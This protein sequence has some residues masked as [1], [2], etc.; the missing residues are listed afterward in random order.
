[1]DKEN[2]NNQENMKGVISMFNK[3][4]WKKIVSYIEPGD[5][6][7]RIFHQPVKT[8]EASAARSMLRASTPTDRQVGK[9]KSFSTSLNSA[10]HAGTSNS[11]FL[12]AAGRRL[13]SLGDVRA[14][15]SS[16]RT[17]ARERTFE[18]VR[19]LKATAGAKFNP[20][21]IAVP[22]TA[23]LRAHLETPAG[24]LSKFDHAGLTDPEYERTQWGA[25]F[26]AL[27][28]G[29]D[30]ILPAAL[31]TVPGGLQRTGDGGFTEQLQ[32]FGY[33]LPTYET[34]IKHAVGQSGE[35]KV[36]VAGASAKELTSLSSLIN[37]MDDGPRARFQAVVRSCFLA[38]ASPPVG[39]LG[40]PFPVGMDKES[41]QL[42]ILDKLGTRLAETLFGDTTGNKNLQRALTVLIREYTTVFGVKADREVT[43]APT[44][45]T[46]TATIIGDLS[47]A[48]RLDTFKALAAVYNLLPDS[49]GPESFNSMVD[50]LD[51]TQLTALHTNLTKATADG[52]LGLA[53]NI[54]PALAAGGTDVATLKANIKGAAYNGP[55]RESAVIFALEA[56]QDK[57]LATLSS[58]IETMG[59][60]DALPQ[61][62]GNFAGRPWAN[63]VVVGEFLA[64]LSVA[65][66]G[67][68]DDMG[69]ITQTALNN[70]EF[71]GPAL[72]DGIIFGEGDSVRIEDVKGV[73]AGI[74]G[75]SSGHG[76]TAMD[77]FVV[78]SFRE[79]LLPGRATGTHA[80]SVVDFSTR[81]FGRL[82]QGNVDI[83]TVRERKTA[84]SAPLT[85]AAVLTALDDIGLEA[86]VRGRAKMLPDAAGKPVQVVY[87]L[88][89]GVADKPMCEL[90]AEDIETRYEWDGTGYA[91]KSLGT[92]IGRAALA[93]EEVMKLGGTSFFLGGNV[94]EL[95]ATGDAV[96]HKVE[97]SNL[98]QIPYD[99]A[100]TG[101]ERKVMH[102]GTDR[103]DGWYVQMTPAEQLADFDGQ[104]QY[105]GGTTT[106]SASDLE[107]LGRAVGMTGTFTAP[108]IKAYL[109]ANPG[110]IQTAMKTIAGIKAEQAFDASVG[111][112]SDAEAKA[113]FEALVSGF[114]KEM[115]VDLGNRLGF[116]ATPFSTTNR[117][118]I[119]NYI[120]HN[121][122]LTLPGGVLCGKRIT[123]AKIATRMIAEMKQGTEVP[124][125]KAIGVPIHG[126]LVQVDGKLL[127]VAG[128]GVFVAN[129]RSAFPVYTVF[130][131]CKVGGPAGSLIDLAIG[132]E[133]TVVF[134]D[135]GAG[136]QKAF[137]RNTVDGTM[138]SVHEV[139]VLDTGSSR[140]L[141]IAGQ[142]DIGGGRWFAAGPP[143]EETQDVKHFD[144]TLDATHDR[145]QTVTI[146][147]N[148]YS[149]QANGSYAAVRDTLRE[150][151][152]SVGGQ[153][154]SLRHSGEADLQ[155]WSI[156]TGA[157]ASTGSGG[158]TPTGGVLTKHTAVILF[159]EGA[160]I[161]VDSDGKV[162]V[163]TFL[164][165]GNEVVVQK[166]GHGGTAD[167]NIAKK[168]NMSLGG[169]FGV[170]PTQWNLGYFVL[171]GNVQFLK[172]D[173]TKP[174]S[175]MKG[176]DV[177]PLGTS[178][179]Y[180]I[181]VGVEPGGTTPIYNYVVKNTAGDYVTANC[182]ALDGISRLSYTDGAVSKDMFIRGDAVLD[183]A[184]I[185]QDTIFNGGA[186][187]QVSYLFTSEEA[188]TGSPR[189]YRLDAGGTQLAKAD[190]G[191]ATTVTAE[192][193][194]PDAD[195][196]KL[197]ASLYRV[198]QSI[199]DTTKQSIVPMYE[200]DGVG[201]GVTSYEALTQYDP[202][203]FGDTRTARIT[204]AALG[205]EKLENG[206]YAYYSA[207]RQMYAYPVDASGLFYRWS[208]AAIKEVGDF[209]SDQVSTPMTVKLEKQIE[210]GFM[211]L[212][213]TLVDS[214]ILTFSPS[215]QRRFTGDAS[216]KKATL[217]K[218]MVADGAQWKQ[219][220]T[221]LRNKVL[222]H[223]CHE[224]KMGLRAWLNKLDMVQLT[225]F[226]ENQKSGDLSGL[227]DIDFSA[228]DIAT[229][230]TEVFA[231]ILGQLHIKEA[232]GIFSQVDDTSLVDFD[233]LS[234]V[235]TSARETHKAS[236]DLALASMADYSP[237]ILGESAHKILDVLTKPTTED[238]VVCGLNI[239]GLGLT[240][241]AGTTITNLGDSLFTPAT[242]AVFDQVLAVVTTIASLA[243]LKTQLELLKQTPGAIAAIVAEPTAGDSNLLGVDLAGC[244]DTDEA[245]I[246]FILNAKGNAARVD[247]ADFSVANLALAGAKQIV[248][249]KLVIAAEDKVVEFRAL[250]GRF[251]DVQLLEFLSADNNPTDNG[252]ALG[253][254]DFSGKNKA[255]IITLVIDTGKANSNPASSLD[256]GIRCATSRL[257][258]TAV[259]GDTETAL[260]TLLGK[261]PD[262]ELHTFA[263]TLV[264]A[265]YDATGVDITKSGVDYVVAQLKAGESNIT[266]TEYDA[267]FVAVTALATTALKAAMDATAI[268]LAAVLEQFKTGVDAGGAVTY[269]ERGL[270]ACFPSLSSGAPIPARGKDDLVTKYLS[271]ADPMGALAAANTLATT[272]LDGRRTALEVELTTTLTGATTDPSTNALQPGWQQFC[273][274][275]GG[276]T[277]IAGYVTTASGAATTSL[278]T[279]AKA[280]IFADAQIAS[281]LVSLQANIRTNIANLQDGGALSRIARTTMGISISGGFT[282][283]TT[284]RSAILA[285]LSNTAL[286]V[287][288]QVS[289]EILTALGLFTANRATSV[290]GLLPNL[291]V[292]DLRA[293]LPLIISNTDIVDGGV[294]TGYVAGGLSTYTAVRL[295]DYITTGTKQEDAAYTALEGI[296]N[297]RRQD[298]VQAA[299]AQIAVIVARPGGDPEKLQLLE[300]FRVA[301]SIDDFPADK[302]TV[303]D[304]SAWLGTQIAVNTKNTGEIREAADLM[305]QVTDF[306][307]G[308]DDIASANAG[309]GTNITE[310][311]QQAILVA[312]LHPTVF[313]A[314]T[315]TVADRVAH[316]KTAVIRKPLA[317]IRIS[318]GKAT[319]LLARERASVEL[320]VVLGA[321]A[322]TSLADPVQMQICRFA[323]KQLTGNNAMEFGTGAAAADKAVVATDDAAGRAAFLF[324]PARFAE[325]NAG[326]DATDIQAVKVRL[327]EVK[328]K[329]EKFRDLAEWMAQIEVVAN[330]S[331]A[332]QKAALNSL[333][334][335]AD[336]KTTLAECRAQV[337]EEAA[338]QTSNIDEMIAKASAVQNL[339]G[340][341]V[342]ITRIAGLS[343]A[344]QLAALKSMIPTA[345]AR[346]AVNDV[347]SGMARI[348]EQEVRALAPDKVIATADNNVL[349]RAEPTK[350]YAT[351]L[352]GVAQDL[353]E[354][355]AKAV[356]TGVMAHAPTTFAP[357]TVETRML[358][359]LS[360]AAFGNVAPNDIDGNKLQP[361]VAAKAASEVTWTAG[362]ITNVNT[363]LDGIAGLDL[364]A[365]GLDA[366]TGEP[367][368]LA[369]LTACAQFIEGDAGVVY[370]WDVVAT[371]NQRRLDHVGGATDSSI[372]LADLRD[373]AR[374]TG[375]NGRELQ[376]IKEQLEQLQGLV[377]E[378]LALKPLGVGAQAMV[379]SL[380]GVDPTGRF[381][382]S[383][384]GLLQTT[385]TGKSADKIAEMR[386]QLQLRSLAQ[387]EVLGAGDAVAVQRA[388]C[389]SIRRELV[390]GELGFEFAADQDLAAMTDTLM[391]LGEVTGMSVT[392][393]AAQVGLVHD[394]ISNMAELKVQLQEVVDART[395]DGGP[396][397][398]I[399]ITVERKV[400]L[401]KAL[402]EAPPVI[403]YTGRTSPTNTIDD[404]LADRMAALQSPAAVLGKTAEQI[405]ELYSA[406]D[407]GLLTETARYD[408]NTAVEEI[409][410]FNFGDLAGADAIKTALLQ[411]VLRQGA[412]VGA[413]FG[414]ATAGAVVGAVDV[415]AQKEYLV[416]YDAGFNLEYATVTPAYRRGLELA[417]IAIQLMEVRGS[418]LSDTDKIAI[419]DSIISDAAGKTG[420][421]DARITYILTNEICSDGTSAQ[422][423]VVALGGI[424]NTVQ[425]DKAAKT[426]ERTTAI[427]GTKAA[428]TAVRTCVVDDAVKD[429][430]LADVLAAI[431]HGFTFVAGA[432]GANQVS[433]ASTAERINY[434]EHDDRFVGLDISLLNTIKVAAQGVV[435][436]VQGV[437][438][439]EIATLGTAIGTVIT[440]A[441]NPMNEAGKLAMLEVLRAGATCGL[442]AFIGVDFAAQKTELT[443]T[444]IAAKSTA[445]IAAITVQVP[446]LMAAR[447]AEVTAL[448][449]ALD[450]V[451]AAA[452]A[453]SDDLQKAI[454]IGL[455]NAGADVHDFGAVDAPAMVTYLKAEGI[456]TKTAAEITALKDRVASMITLA[457]QLSVMSTEL[458][459]GDRNVAL[460]KLI[461]GDR[462]A[463][464]F[465][466]DTTEARM[467]HILQVETQ[468]PD[469]PG[470]QRF[471]AKTESLGQLVGMLAQLVPTGAGDTAEIK[472]ALDQVI[473]Q[474]GGANFVAAPGGDT[475][476]AR[477]TH[478]VTTTITGQT[479]DSLG[480]IAKIAKRE[481]DILQIQ[482]AF[483]GFEDANL[484]DLVAYCVAGNGTDTTVGLGIDQAVIDGAATD[485]DFTALGNPD[486]KRARLV[487][488]FRTMGPADVGKVTAALTKT[489]ALQFDMQIQAFEAVLQAVPVA[490]QDAQFDALS[491]YVAAATDAAANPGL[492]L[493]INEG[494]AYST[495]AT[496]VEKQARL[497]AVLNTGA[498]LAKVGQV[499]AKVGEIRVAAAKTSFNDKISVVDDAHVLDALKDYCNAG[500]PG[501]LG[502]A[503]NV[504]GWATLANPAKRAALTG[505]MTAGNALVI[506]QATTRLHALKQMG[507]ARA[508]FVAALG[509][510]PA[511]PILSDAGLAVFQEI[512]QKQV[513]PA[514]VFV[515]LVGADQNA[516]RDDLIA[517]IIAGLNAE[518][519][520]AA[521]EKATAAV[522]FVE[523]ALKQ[524]VPGTEDYTVE[525]LETL[526]TNLTG[527]T[528]AAEIAGLDIEAFAPGDNLQAGIGKVAVGLA[529][530]A[531]VGAAFVVALAQAPIAAAESN[532]AVGLARLTDPQL[533]LLRDAI[534]WQAD[535]P[536]MPLN[537]EFA[538][539]DVDLAFTVVQDTQARIAVLTQ[540]MKADGVT[541]PVV[542]ME[543][544]LAMVPVTEAATMFDTAVAGFS[545]DELGVLLA[546]LRT[547]PSGAGELFEGIDLTTCSTTRRLMDI[548]S[549]DGTEGVARLQ[550]ATELAPRAKAEQSLRA[551][552]ASF[553]TLQLTEL[554][555]RING[556][557]GGG[558]VP[559]S[560]LAGDIDITAAGTD[561]ERITAIADA[562]RGIADIA[563]ATALFGAV[564]TEARQGA[565]ERA[566]VAA[567][568]GTT[569]LTPEQLGNVRVQLSAYFAQNE[570]ALTGFTDIP[571]FT[572]AQNADARRD[573]I[574][575]ALTANGVNSASSALEF[576]TQIIGSIRASHSLRAV[577]AGVT[578]FPTVE[579]LRGQINGLKTDPASAF[580]GIADIVGGAATEIDAV[581]GRVVDACNV[582]TWSPVQKTAAFQAAER[583]VG[584]AVAE[585][586]FRV[587]IAAIADD[588]SRAGTIR[589]LAQNLELIRARAAGVTPEL[590][591]ITESIPTGDGVTLD[592]VIAALKKGTDPVA[593]IGFAAGK[594]ALAV[595]E[596]G[597]RTL[598]SA[599]SLNLSDEHVKQLAINL[600]AVR[601]IN[602]ALAGIAAE[603]PHADGVSLDD[604]IGSLKGATNPDQALALASTLAPIAKNE[605]VVRVLAMDATAMAALVAQLQLFGTGAGEPLEGVAS[606]I[607]LTVGH[608]L[609]DLITGLKAG[610]NPA[611]A[612]SLAVDRQ[613][614]LVTTK[615]FGQEVTDA[616][617]DEHG[618]EFL[619][620]DLEAKRTQNDPGLAGFAGVIPAFTAGD[621]AG[622]LTELKALF[623]L[624]PVRA[625]AVSG[626]GVASGLIPAAKYKQVVREFSAEQL[627]TLRTRINAA[628][629]PDLNGVD[630]GD[631]NDDVVGTR[632]T[633]LLT[634]LTTPEVLTA[635]TALATTIAQEL[636]DAKAAF[637]LAVPDAGPTAFTPVELETVRATLEAKNVVT[638]AAFVPGDDLAPAR[639]AALLTALGTD[640]AKI[641]H[642]QSVATFMRA[643]GGFDG[644]QLEVLR[645]K[646]SAN[647]DVALGIRGVAFEATQDTAERST[648]IL[649]QLETKA[650]FDAAI[651]LA[652]EVT[653]AHAT[654]LG[655]FNAVV[656]TPANPAAPGDDEFR[657]DM[658]EDFR[659]LLVDSGVITLAPAAFTG[660]TAAKKA[661]LLTA[662]GADTAKLTQATDIARQYIADRQAQLT[663]LA[664]PAGDGGLLEQ[665]IT[666]DGFH[667]G[668]V[669]A[670]KDKREKRHYI[671]TSIGVVP[672][673]LVGA[674]E[675]D[676]NR[677]A[678]LCR[679]R[680]VVASKNKSLAEL[681]RM[682]AA[683]KFFVKLAQV[684]SAT[685]NGLSGVGTDY[686]VA[687]IANSKLE[688]LAPH[689]A[690]N[691]DD[692][693][694][695]VAGRDQLTTELYER[696][697]RELDP[698]RAAVI[699]LD[700]SITG[701]GRVAVSD[702]IKASLRLG[703]FRVLT[704]NVAANFGPGDTTDVA[705]RGAIAGSGALRALKAD[706]A[707]NS[708]EIAAR[709]AKTVAIT[710]LAVRM[711]AIVSSGLSEV[712]QKQMLNDIQ[713][714]LGA[715]R[716]VL[717]AVRV[718][719]LIV[720]IL[721]NV[722]ALEATDTATILAQA[723]LAPNP[724]VAARAR[725]FGVQL[726]AVTTLSSEDDKNA[727]LTAVIA[728]LGDTAAYTGADTAAAKLTFLRLPARLTGKSATQFSDAI[729][730]AQTRVALFN[731]L[732]SMSGAAAPVE[733][734]VAKE[735]LATVR[736]GL[737]FLGA[738]IFL[739]TDDLAARTT[740]FKGAVAGKSVDQVEQMTTGLQT[741]MAA[742]KL[743]VDGLHAEVHRVSFG[744]ARDQA[745]QK[746]EYSLER[747]SSAQLATLKAS[748]D[749]AGTGTNLDGFTLPVLTGTEA[750]D[751]Q[752]VFMALV[753]REDEAVDQAADL[754]RTVLAG[755]TDEAK[756]RFALGKIS[757]EQLDALRLGINEADG[758]LNTVDIPA[759]DP[760][761]NAPA[762][763][764][765]VIVAALVDG[766]K[767]LAAEG[768]ARNLPLHS[769]SDEGL[770][771]AVQVAFQKV[772]GGLAFT[773]PE[774]NVRASELCSEGRVKPLSTTELGLA[775]EKLQVLKELAIELESLSADNPAEYAMVDKLALTMTAAFVPPADEAAPAGVSLDVKMARR[776]KHIIEH[777]AA[778]GGTTTEFADLKDR[779][780]ELKR[781][782]SQLQAIAL[783]DGI[784]AAEKTVVL[785][786]IV[787]PPVPAGP[788]L[789]GAMP[790]VV[791]TPAF[792]QERVA[793]IMSDTL[794]AKNLADLKDGPLSNVTLLTGLQPKVDARADAVTA[795]HAQFD[796][797]AG[798]GTLDEP[799]KKQLLLG[800]LRARSFEH[801]TTA[802]FPLGA[803]TQEADT[804]ANRVSYL[805]RVNYTAV[806]RD[807]GVLQT[808]RIIQVTGR[809]GGRVTAFK[810]LAASLDLIDADIDLNSADKKAILAVVLNEAGGPAATFPDAAD[811][812]SSVRHLKQLGA[813]FKKVHRVAMKANVDRL[814]ALKK[815]EVMAAKTEY[816][817]A[818]DLTSFHS[819]T[820]G[821]VPAEIAFLRAVVPVAQ[822]GDGQ[823]ATLR[824]AA[825]PDTLLAGKSLAEIAA[826][827]LR[828]KT[829][830]VEPL[831]T[832]V[833]GLVSAVPL[834]A[835]AFQ[836]SN[837]GDF[838]N[839]N[840]IMGNILKWS[841]FGIQSRNITSRRVTDI[842]VVASNIEEGKEPLAARDGGANVSDTAE[843]GAVLE[844]ATLDQYML[845]AAKL[846]FFTALATSIG[847]SEHAKTEEILLR[848]GGAA[849]TLDHAAALRSATVAR[850]QRGRSDLATYLED[851]DLSTFTRALKYLDEAVA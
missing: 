568:G 621:T 682:V 81:F 453:L 835:D 366:T 347:A 487:T 209:M 375:K 550:R 649:E 551:N 43:P 440:S 841:G 163:G 383:V 299:A 618:L 28:A 350:Q 146:G 821:G 265:D 563:Q 312:L 306:G 12:R 395:V 593:A 486:L 686:G 37:S 800:V 433:V 241:P 392:E 187:T 485:P 752:L 559:F 693:I 387:V 431:R 273:E 759:F 364:T 27:D 310:E 516:K 388:I 251:S 88:N 771:G 445:Q 467:L 483:V 228:A 127:Q 303:A 643:L 723:T 624:M 709:T 851:K 732:H 293:A 722:V 667:G 227:G 511:A 463:G 437:R 180:R 690:L 840:T 500:A 523:E 484:G 170:A 683:T 406:A 26:C 218:M 253:W 372:M 384:S 311:R 517:K 711:Q 823:I 195:I 749:V 112:A 254:L 352:V 6:I 762:A 74:N 33:G 527:L 333:V 219:G 348:L 32:E 45:D 724:I 67:G 525:R 596:S 114:S 803:A 544:A 3:D 261:I 635:A 267:I 592:Q 644:G 31:S 663:L 160:P 604:I 104:V 747:L 236:M 654:A 113:S 200:A 438:D 142:A 53:I 748:V 829:V 429:P 179:V 76:V 150:Y 410:V 793:T 558:Q 362:L 659:A 128:D 326:T 718:S 457:Q 264:I 602:P 670:A 620:A 282:R 101:D 405:N 157:S 642:A 627:E 506:E 828:A 481:S 316:L 15:D 726:E 688:T 134:I 145:P 274:A 192:S 578:D 24:S 826:I 529:G 721:T 151:R 773:R 368:K 847:N 403:A 278:E 235:L 205:R 492:G 108:G 846:R 580:N 294:I 839:N 684:N 117:S 300:Q 343:E 317:E 692:G 165:V 407:L 337:L 587:A 601:A 250:L 555:V 737:A 257:A 598:A 615:L 705:Q 697:F 358:H 575:A 291:G 797:I 252:L 186:A 412:G 409:A 521:F 50:G 188:A 590:A 59:K 345:V 733:D 807:P 758:D 139:A 514:A 334:P 258:M 609:E 131:S 238:V 197:T 321:A 234:S 735:M 408:M 272:T 449:T 808:E 809:I 185:F 751:R 498:D 208:E 295:R 782:N 646:L 239:K 497:I 636:A 255:E 138:A 665:V 215:V 259:T 423:D 189:I 763:K 203:V 110:N 532:L 820:G 561:P 528:G 781:I 566:F 452:T 638:L 385:V 41:K 367:V 222:K 66:F 734:T 315:D 341:L 401:I 462:A 29:R 162:P 795:L 54:P 464:A 787:P 396:G 328:A 780:V 226:Y 339:A 391:G 622:R 270:R 844:A 365:I 9:L 98:S 369:L 397:Q 402:M 788:V 100:G 174:T 435:A 314:G 594:Q 82:G 232:G 611:G 770:R 420:T 474:N 471:A 750:E 17:A 524:T 155:E 116:G 305:T 89:D 562:I 509:A 44:V 91:E 630:L 458:G 740:Y 123:A 617:L 658:L 285:E 357:D 557:R 93:R 502:L 560:H 691:R 802:S 570:V 96:L 468:G 230:R 164:A 103:K 8:M 501:G 760:A 633:E 731:A 729:K 703:A 280:K 414:A 61:L 477:L 507:V 783:S 761:V 843:L 73:L 796:A 700:T 329:V 240:L 818:I 424:A 194:M 584:I 586:P 351:A 210:D 789:P 495:L 338:K 535:D 436:N 353:E 269:D 668:M 480:T 819:V 290:M 184:F 698:N 309:A 804:V 531:D 324:D 201:S 542:A 736:G 645:G 286:S 335:E 434:L 133:Q 307:T 71:T 86:G 190:D 450:T 428:L 629:D 262:A 382:D 519:A 546:N 21:P 673:V 614:V 784:T 373:T 833:A 207:A 361:L 419:L 599:G 168:R 1:M 233:K 319:A 325:I 801:S 539:V 794:V 14:A 354:G 124:Y 287:V 346:A 534:H 221:C 191:V 720:A 716:S 70:F 69:S 730:T 323:V 379:E 349:T 356:L 5:A 389:T 842:G 606:P 767:R 526:R 212:P 702:E 196:S 607:V 292:E 20:A 496:L 625:Q 744:S 473:L 491:L 490:G 183:A 263:G 836:R 10:K 494:T 583:M 370:V 571:A 537:A 710:E 790:V 704:A 107:Q 505:G 90:T 229:K 513:T 728:G 689:F 213:D 775:R 713:F 585:Q 679:M 141:Y 244:A 676:S 393:L 757:E 132:T 421:V 377:A 444:L 455:A 432:A 799:T 459:A 296:I 675:T 411:E 786:G 418:D 58:T 845:M 125:R 129:V 727:I 83:S 166:A 774:L 574:L 508:A 652:T 674:S 36:S 65:C 510:D 247:P 554:V 260:K 381:E 225:G 798:D 376:A 746:L 812:A 476:A 404:E 765:D 175:L 177:I 217:R 610:A 569:P 616:H 298:A 57:D 178:G 538:R 78:K 22:D 764:R 224:E 543:H 815:A 51:E 137:V 830:L 650:D 327:E 456:Q 121:L 482:T 320:G 641:G 97:G 182:N 777:P 211:A 776:M 84:L 425:A 167:F 63:K 741:Q 707:D 173:G 245:R 637:E 791:I 838:T 837:L 318:V 47:A 634:G 60:A 850:P 169:P 672:G 662:L 159:E 2:M 34:E 344:A 92:T 80:V 322:F 719:D 448:G 779:V 19:L 447:A 518:Q 275:A 461:E 136:V 304:Q 120:M 62:L 589:Q 246:Q 626:L 699:A 660:N 199:I 541:T 46:S 16:A 297:G 158:S 822:H 281:K 156:L 386:L 540:A 288:S 576:A 176:S 628:T 380:P 148:V 834:A 470:L 832:I 632:R 23:P 708:V 640:T 426:L 548:L 522:P 706:P 99:A 360:Q 72:R 417:A 140:Y 653:D 363:I 35:T 530:V 738:D 669:G 340:H 49:Y 135:V 603:I 595:E 130:N 18:F 118:A 651:V 547:E 105:S 330:L 469:L 623:T 7:R 552:L 573:V 277:D 430:E 172:T 608:E 413:S 772:I 813:G 768:L 25:F 677:D 202:T 681:K 171:D 824:A 499:I 52:G 655:V 266:D 504:N 806:D 591:G 161:A 204:E 336:R 572:G 442:D 30:E 664:G 556:E 475:V 95:R 231:A 460:D 55:Q 753:T 79:N 715:G 814:L 111:Y 520:L 582:G 631:F 766:P 301:G 565:A 756:L 739:P 743:A 143:I 619:H 248:H 68:I 237:Q 685:R 479:A 256:F 831:K 754:A 533:E 332:N 493:D 696:A 613:A 289:R 11:G 443:T 119:A 153:Q 147:T 115:L 279:L 605:A 441:E 687:I 849:G 817:T 4:F 579:L 154:V 126:D 612:L 331:E 597:L 648:H 639:R 701:L 415:G 661:L 394:Y 313:V 515:A 56:R 374:T 284:Y 342:G 581:K 38:F 122:P 478:I 276:A 308:L 714:A 680:A 242:I 220:D 549:K 64:K 398:E 488:V 778:V 785:N 144:F 422:P 769:V 102:V 439:Q 206:S 48:Q 75:L 503:V 466:A 647:A 427:A 216:A 371:P 465:S 149:V 378:S 805:K 695:A 666:M 446:I 85:S 717:P 283:N 193:V 399:E 359:L 564:A 400:A 745:A 792:V 416:S 536:T 42:L 454:L 755:D 827:T 678:P 198:G 214:T 390:P 271:E 355:A 489:K 816:A 40:E 512:A 243:M 657:A 588:T 94:Y 600:D 725:S 545:D 742:H 87:I 268:T 451:V 13:F 553:T 302:I 656:T 39:P 472:A 181:K 249:S 106:F 109:L 694:G 77:K 577:L 811:V 825:L 223:L 152:L 671:F 712:A 848:L 567:V 810:D